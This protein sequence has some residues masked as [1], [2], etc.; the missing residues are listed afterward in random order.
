MYQFCDGNPI[1]ETDPFGLGAKETTSTFSWIMNSQ[2]MMN[3]VGILSQMIGLYP[4]NV[5]DPSQPAP[6][7]GIGKYIADAQASLT[8]EDQMLMMAVS[9]SHAPV[10]ES[11]IPA[12]PV[13]RSGQPINIAPGNNPPATIDGVDYSGHSLDQMQGRGVP[14]SVIQNTINVG[15]SFPTGAGTVGYFDP[16]NNVRVI[17]ST[18]TG[19][20]VTV[21]PGK[22]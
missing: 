14:P 12:E 20:V 11:P 8:P 9:I 18:T 1:S 2:P 16:V 19:K 17:V 6:T 5:V 22:P 3:T 21:I 13:G 7:S 4:V 10:V 15:Q